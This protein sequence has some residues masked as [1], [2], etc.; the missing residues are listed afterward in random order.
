MPSKSRPI[1]H[2]RLGT[3][4]ELHRFATAFAQGHLGLLVLLGPPGVGKSQAVRE[5]VGDSACYVSG[6]ASAFGIYI[7]AFY[8]RDEP[9]VLDDVDGLARDRQGVRLLKALCQSDREKTVSWFTHAAALEKLCVPQTFRTKSQIGIIA[10]SWTHNEDIQALEDRGHVVV[11]DPSPL[12][13][14]LK[15]ATW[16]WDQEVFDFVAAHLHLVERPSL[17]SYIAAWERKR[18]SLPWQK[19]ILDRCLSGTAA[20]VAK[21]RADSKF[22]SEEERVRAFVEG[23]LGCRATY[24]NYVN[25]LRTPVAVPR[26]KLTNMLAP[27]SMDA[28]ESVLD[29]LKRRHR[30]LGNG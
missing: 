26:I 14:H 7:Q 20:E 9:I 17:R 22:A 12:E 10:N 3:Y 1:F 15:A 2:T 24:F 6:N 11:F 21:L 25:K 18:A 8:H 23:G 30:R 27:N 13:V 29:L 28:P 19:A 16:F 4:A 5:V